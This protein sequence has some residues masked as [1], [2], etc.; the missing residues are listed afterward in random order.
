MPTSYTTE[1]SVAT[2]PP[3]HALQA[4]RA[5]HLKLASHGNHQLQVACIL[6][7]SVQLCL[8]TLAFNATDFGHLRKDAI[9]LPDLLLA[10]AAAA[11]PD[12]RGN[13]RWDIRNALDA[14]VRGVRLR[15]VSYSVIR[16]C[17]RKRESLT[18]VGGSTS[19]CERS[20]SVGAA[21]APRPTVH[22]SPGER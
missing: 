9:A 14:L 8:P 17:S 13:L 7:G 12:G 15:G 18:S 20:T 16:L 21:T 1:T 19:V 22:R 2:P 4:A 6:P 3:M 10:A 5:T 11:A